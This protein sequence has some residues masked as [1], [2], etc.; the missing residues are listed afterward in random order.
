L[1]F[2]A[3][4]KKAN[5]ALISV[6]SNTSL[7]TL[8]V[9][10]GILSGS[11]S[12]ISEAIHSGID[13][14]ASFIAYCSVKISSKPP[15]YEHPY[16]H[17]KIENFSGLIEGLLIFIAAFFIINEAVVKLINPSEVGETWIGI[18][19]MFVSAI[20]NVVVSKFLYKVAKEEDSMALEADALHLKTDVYTSIGVGVGL[21]AL[22][23]TKLVILDSLIAISVAL[24]I[25]KEAYH[26]CDNALKPLIDSRLSEE[27]EAKICIVMESYK[28]H[29]ID[30][31]NLCTR[32][33]GNTKYIEFH[34]TVNKRLSV[35]ESHEIC[36][37][38]E[39]DLEE[40]LKNTDVLIHIEPGE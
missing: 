17:G 32:K 19:I 4:N 13:L 9:F 7:I 10:A 1:K 27:E 25:M 8:K 28:D 22:E 33:A 26:L 35:E 31:H 14:I 39:R 2:K 12:I 34:M 5:A 20:V 3:D 18:I 6:I 23:I 38:I 29:I 15:D 30:Y 40:V 36:E 37:E 11:V 16:G 21:I 24:L